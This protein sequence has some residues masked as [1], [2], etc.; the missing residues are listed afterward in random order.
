MSLGRFFPRRISFPPAS[1]AGIALGASHITIQNVTVQDISVPFYEGWAGIVI[2]KQQVGP[3]VGSDNLIDHC[4]ISDMFG[5]YSYYIS[6]FSANNY[7]GNDGT[8]EQCTV[9]NNTISG[10]GYYTGIGVGCSSNSTVVGNTVSNVATGFFC[11]TGYSTGITIKNNTFIATY[12]VH[13]G[14]GSPAFFNNSAIQNNLITLTGS[15]GVGIGLTLNESNIT[16]THNTITLQNAND[17]A[18]GITL[19]NMSPGT[20]GNSVTGNTIVSTLQNMGI[21]ASQNTLVPYGQTSQK[22]KSVSSSSSSGP[23]AVKSNSAG[24]PNATSGV[25]TSSATT[26]FSN[27]AAAQAQATAAQIEAQATQM[28]Q[29]ADASGASIVTPDEQEKQLVAQI[30]ALAHQMATPGN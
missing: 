27:S 9:S 7:T 17:G 21:D 22:K 6:A 5:I 8:T 30:N 16:V 28:A 25:V 2:A 11:D 24:G 4:T 1:G 19:T 23:A 29:S 12:G 13:L 15:S 10:N 3:K 20:T 26:A 14:V 18:Y